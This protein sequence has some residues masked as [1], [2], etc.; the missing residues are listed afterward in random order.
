MSNYADKFVSF[1]YMSTYKNF[2]KKNV[3][4]KDTV[5][6]V[7]SGHGFLKPLVEGQGASY[8]G[9]DPRLSLIHI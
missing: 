4:D 3:L 6:D 9:V 8:F 2:I 1:L 7:G 5:L